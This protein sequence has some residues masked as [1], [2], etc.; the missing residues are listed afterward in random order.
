MILCI[1]ADNTDVYI[2]LWSE[3]KEIVGKNWQ[4]GRE[5]STQILS[6]IKEYCER[7]AISIEQLDG[8]I[9]YEGPGS[10]TGLRISISVTNSIGYSYDIPVIGS[11]G[12]N[13]IID[14]M[15]KLGTKSK[16]VSISPVYGG[17]VYTTKPKK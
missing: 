3:N 15:K 6:V 17:E 4:A 7:V 1:K 9:V 5:L 8:I 14:G 13:W 16:F 12:E 2:G 10:Y 11:S